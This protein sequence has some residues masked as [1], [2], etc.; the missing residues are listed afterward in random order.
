MM[1]ENIVSNVHQRINVDN[2]GGLLLM[3]NCN[4]KVLAPQDIDL[5]ITIKLP[6]VT[7]FPP[8]SLS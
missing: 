6:E 3:D 4:L 5:P 8:V 7:G 2:I 1:V